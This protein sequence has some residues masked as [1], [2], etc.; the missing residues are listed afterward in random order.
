LKRV[1]LDASVALSWFLDNPI[2]D[3]AIAV[4]GAI[5]NGTRAVV[6]SLWHLEIAN[7]LVVAERRRM[8]AG[9]ALVR[10]LKDI[11]QLVAESIDTQNDLVSI[12]QAVTTAR[13]YDLTAYDA[14][15]LDTARHE[16]LPLA[17][18]DRGLR[19]A[20]GRAGVDL[21]R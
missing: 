17:T 2:T 15:Y 6:P 5:V 8:L 4:R 7:T 12:R 19:A 14:V 16:A 3:Y 18:L 11:E 9:D 13:T 21:F 20:A 1:V 10:S